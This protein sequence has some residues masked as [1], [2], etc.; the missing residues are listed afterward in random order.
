[1]D[2]MDTTLAHL[3]TGSKPAAAIRI[4]IHHVFSTI[5][6]DVYGDEGRLWTKKTFCFAAAISHT[7]YVSLVEAPGRKDNLPESQE[8]DEAM[9][10]QSVIAQ[11]APN[12]DQMAIMHEVFDSLKTSLIDQ[13]QRQTT[14]SGMRDWTSTYCVLGIMM[15]AAHRHH[16]IIPKLELMLKPRSDISPWQA[17]DL[18]PLPFDKRRKSSEGDAFDEWERKRDQQLADLDGEQWCGIASTCL[19]VRHLKIILD[20]RF[21]K[22]SGY[23]QVTGE[24]NDQGRRFAISS[25]NHRGIGFFSYF[26]IHFDARYG[27][28]GAPHALDSKFRGYMTRFGILGY[29][30]RGSGVELVPNGFFW[31][32]KSVWADQELLAL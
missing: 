6:W 30:N 14:Y 13:L 9:Q 24:G 1:M 3:L 21:S 18:L 7:G 25:I 31:L 23:W 12:S 11:S 19:H 29:W 10:S 27:T 8:C 5:K 22:K 32:W 15:E 20:L 16:V 26:H 4:G 2:V 17:P 28:N